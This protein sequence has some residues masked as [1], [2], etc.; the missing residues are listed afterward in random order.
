ME[1]ILDNGKKF[2][3]N[4]IKVADGAKIVMASSYFASH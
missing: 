3:S 4:A 1:N 2:F